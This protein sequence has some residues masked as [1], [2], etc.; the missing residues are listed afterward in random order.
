MGSSNTRHTSSRYLCD[1]WVHFNEPDRGHLIAFQ[2]IEE[3]PDGRCY[4]KITV[5]PPGACGEGAILILE[6]EIAMR[7]VRGKRQYRLGV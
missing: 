7:R 5:R 3:T 6:E 4:Q 1:T 2:E